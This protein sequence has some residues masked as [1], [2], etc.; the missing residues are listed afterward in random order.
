LN[1]KRFAEA[2]IVSVTDLH[3]PVEDVIKA[4]YIP[5]IGIKHNQQPVFAVLEL[6]V[7]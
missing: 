7:N 6:M 2:H 4:I 3:L 1:I 5:Q